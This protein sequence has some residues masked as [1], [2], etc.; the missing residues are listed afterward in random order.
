MLN[1]FALPLFC[2]VL[3]RN[4]KG[5]SKSGHIEFVLRTHY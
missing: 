4:N 2:I 1:A 3:G 5:G